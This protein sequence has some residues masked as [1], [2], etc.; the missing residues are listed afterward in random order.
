MVTIRALFARDLLAMF[1]MAIELRNL[2]PMV[3]GG[4]D[5]TSGEE[6]ELSGPIEMLFTFFGMP[7]KCSTSF[8]KFLYFLSIRALASFSACLLLIA[9]NY[10]SSKLR[11]GLSMLRS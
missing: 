3:F 11:T 2:F 9:S 7:D 5:G 6:G 1:F 8:E 4:G 10:F